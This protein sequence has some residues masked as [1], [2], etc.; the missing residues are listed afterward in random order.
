MLTLNGKPVTPTIFPDKT[1]QVWKLPEEDL[2]RISVSIVWRFE[3][4]GEF[5]HLAQLCSLLSARGALFE[6]HLPY[7]PYARQDKEIANDRTFALLTFSRLLAKLYPKRV[8]LYDPHN[9]LPL[10]NEL[11][12]AH[13]FQVEIRTFEREA[14]EAYATCGADAWCFPDAGAL[15]RYGNMVAADGQ[16]RIVASKVRDQ[17]TGVITGTRVDGAVRGHRAMIIDD[18]CDGGATFIA[19]AKL[20]REQGAES[21]FLFV[22]HGIFSRGLEPLFAAGI[23]RIFT[24]EGEKSL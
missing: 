2:D 12:R 24:P 7:L 13:G 15:A 4:E 22:S 11:T 18:I 10:Q 5:M 8:V 14:R 9:A 21:V 3:S 1:S 6:I 16:W 17:E 23:D 20:L 19:L